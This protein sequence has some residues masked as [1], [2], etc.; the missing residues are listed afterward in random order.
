MSWLAIYVSFGWVVRI[1][2]VPVILRRQFAPGA[3]VAWLGIIFLHPYIGFVL[4]MTVGETRL[5]PNRVERHRQLVAHFRSALRSATPPPEK[6]GHG[7]ISDAYEPMVLQ[8]QKISGL[9]ILGGNSVE[10]LTECTPMVERLVADIDAAASQVHLLYYMIVADET[11]ERVAAALERAAKRGVVCRVLADAVASRSFFG[12]CGMARRLEAAGVKVAAALPVAPIQRRLPRMDLRNHRKLSVIDGRIAYAGSHNL[13]NPDYGGRHGGPWVDITG[14]YTGPIVIELGV[15]FAEDWAF[16]TNELL[17]V[18]TAGDTTPLADGTPMQVVPTGPTSRD[19]SFERVFLAAIHSARKRVMMTTPYFVP[20]ETT[21]MALVM[22]ADRGADVSL[23][24]PLVP[25][26]LFTAAAGRAQF[27][28]LMDAGIK[29]YLYNRG[30]LHTKSTTIDDT[31]AVFGSANLDVRSFNLN[32]EMTVLMYGAPITG[33]LRA[34][35][36]SYMAD[37]TPLDP[38]EWAARPAWRRYG[39]SAIS[40]LSPLL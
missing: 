8:A 5:G 39:D 34:I 32:F 16:E 28:R 7:V 36:E 6:D 20:D 22:A 3:A 14:R 2:M 12:R 35:Q 40:L 23:L 18:S 4:Y 10:F 31:F 1:L 25:D 24:V 9:P 37:S 27:A 33:K 19:E 29:I 17:S 21:M 15:V 26:H 38:K 11:G 30:L 13:V